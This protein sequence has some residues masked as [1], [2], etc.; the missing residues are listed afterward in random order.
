[1]SE[2]QPAYALDE[3]AQKWRALAE[4][5]RAHLRRAYRQRA[6]EAL[7]Q[8]RAV[9]PR[10]REAIRLTE[11][12]AE[13]PRPARPKAC[14]SA[15]SRLPTCPA[16]ARPELPARFHSI[17]ACRRDARIAAGDNRLTDRLPAGRGIPYVASF[18]RACPP[19][20]DDAC[21]MT[22]ALF[23]PIRLAGSRTREPH[24]RLAD[25]PVQR[26]RRRRIR[27]APQSS[28]HAGQ[29]R[30]RAGRD[31][32]HRR[33][34]PRPHHAWLPRPLF[35]RLRGGVWR[36][37]SPI[38][39]ATAPPSSASRLAHAGRKASAQRPWEGSQRARAGRRSMGDHRAV[40]H[41]VRPEL[42]H[43]RGR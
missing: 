31:R 43:L 2:R 15:R 9:S 11:R 23:S 3:V 24:R 17:S 21:D 28:R 10:M 38:A 33:R 39:A 14:L 37:S 12:W 32:G 25:V 34:A 6:L 41:S 40:G 5:R 8:R 20:S 7:L 30:R 16:A 26:R 4:R 27:L 29:F 35:G 18:P 1:M 13:M 42:A 22:S 19:P 36:A